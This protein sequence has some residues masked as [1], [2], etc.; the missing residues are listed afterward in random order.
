MCFSRTKKTSFL[1]RGSKQLRGTPE[2]QGT[3]AKRALTQ[4]LL[5]ASLWAGCAG[6]TAVDRPIEQVFYYDRNGDGRVDLEKHHFPKMADA[7]WELRDDDY[8][9]RYTKKVLYGYAVVE[10]AVD[11]PVPGKVRVEPKTHL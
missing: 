3:L 6:Q 10:S 11:L 7:D 5:T 9:G 1:L 2:F 8:S 4:L